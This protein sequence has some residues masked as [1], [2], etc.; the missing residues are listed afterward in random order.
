MSPYT[1]EYKEGLKAFRDNLKLSDCPYKTI[2]LVRDRW[3]AGYGRAVAID[4]DNR[5]M[6]HYKNRIS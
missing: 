3:C 2:S 4:Q 1:K 6:S 5:T